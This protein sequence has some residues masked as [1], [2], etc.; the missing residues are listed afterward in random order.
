MYQRRRAKERND[1]KKYKTYDQ[2]MRKVPSLDMYDPD[3]R[4][5]KYVR[6]CDDFLLSFIAPKSEA[7][8]INQRLSDFLKG[9]LKL[10]LSQTKTL[11]THANT[12]PA[13]FLGYDIQVQQSNGY[14]GS[15]GSR[16]ANGQI[17]LKLPPEV[18]RKFCAKYMQK[19]KP[20]HRK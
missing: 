2:K 12:K 18:L 7:K 16:T 20:I 6:Y 3:Y 13:R 11:I 14:R 8:E 10:E 15:G 17:A 9:G 1:H 5:L 19:G 4:R